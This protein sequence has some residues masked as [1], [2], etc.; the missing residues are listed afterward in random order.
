VRCGLAEQ[1]L[2]LK[3]A[4]R[5]PAE[6]AV[7]VL[8]VLG[9]EE[10]LPFPPGSFDLIVRCVLCYHIILFTHRAIAMCYPSDLIHVV[11]QAKTQTPL[12]P[13]TPINTSHTPTP[14]P[15]PTAT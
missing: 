7:E 12:R 8:D 14:P 5:G 9:D 1:G 6:N 10:H 2:L 15:T 4:K 11:Q 13:H 3:P